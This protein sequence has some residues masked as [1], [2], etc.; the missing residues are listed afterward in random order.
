MLATVRKQ[1]F[2]PVLTHTLRSTSVI[3]T[4]TAMRFNSTAGATKSTEDSPDLAF[5]KEFTQKDYDEH[6]KEE[7]QFEKSKDGGKSHIKYNI[8]GFKDLQD[9]G[10]KTAQQQERPED[11]M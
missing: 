11:F 9:K 8:K 7:I 1:L 2:T 6:I 5:S 4:I 3:G 10:D